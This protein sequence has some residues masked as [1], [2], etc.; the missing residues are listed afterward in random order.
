MGASTNYMIKFGADA[1]SVTKAIN[2]LNLDM[3]TLNKVARDSKAAFKLTGDTSQLQTAIT[4]TEKKFELAKKK[5]QDLE[6]ALNGL[7]D[8]NGELPDTVAAKKL[9]SQATAAKSDVNKL[10]AELEDLGKQKAGAEIS[11]DM[12]KASKSIKDAEGSTGKLHNSLKTSGV[13]LGSFIG[14]LGGNIASAGLGMIA[15]VFSGMGSDILEASDS[16]DKFKSTMSFAGKSNKEITNLTNASKKYAD[17]TVYD[18]NTILNT[19]AQLG[20]N[21]V[22]NYGKLVQAAGNLN[23]VVGG[24]NDT[25]GSLSMVLTQTA[26][27][28][29]L[30]TDN[31]NQVADAIPGAS[32]KLQD[33]MKKNGAYTGNFRDAMEK[34]QISSEEFNKAIMDLGMTDTAKKAASSTKTIEGAVGNLQASV[35]TVG[36][37]M[38]NAIK[39]PLTDAIS[40]VANAIPAI[41]TQISGMFSGIN[42]GGLSTVITSIQAAFSKLDFSGLKDLLSAIIPGLIAGFKSFVSSATPGITMVVGAFKNL[43]NALQPVFSVIGSMLVPAFKILGSYL[44]GLF[45]G[46]LSAVS[47]AFNGVAV[48]VKILTPVIRL[49]GKVFTALTPIFS[50]VANWL[51]NLQGS[52]GATSKIFSGVG[53]VLGS[54]G[55]GISS[56]FAGVW[57]RL[58]GAFGSMKS[59]FSAVGRL[60]SSVAKGIGGIPGRIAGWFSGIGGRIAAKFGNVKSIIGGKFSNIVGSISKHFSGITKIG[61]NVVKGIARGITG[62][63]SFLKGII[64]GFVGNTV[65]FIKKLFKIHSPSRL[66]RDEVGTFI[67]QGIGVGMT[68]SKAMGKI[69]SSARTVTNGVVNAFGSMAGGAGLNGGIVRAG[70][71]ATGT[72]SVSTA[73]NSVVFNISGG[74]PNQTANAVRKVL[75]QEKLI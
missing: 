14:T 15:D 35:Q 61:T 71:M 47:T 6:T 45:N 53:K 63:L 21:G 56:T 16:L 59:G 29:K 36:M 50:K 23:A 66:M 22:D 5:A 18:L 33:A 74:D 65:S 24:N 60:F 31:W 43:W 28:G 3:K 64:K 68:T 40:F 73:N 42:A 72:S 67:T 13:A 75:R 70:S 27:A 52:F 34:G 26:G 58:S 48:V 20:A 38:F 39:K 44:G 30:T 51:G 4:A 69:N 49:I 1:S 32:M 2:G 11:D 55:R 25:F 57:S 10:G 37:N 62:G 12:D 46:I 17:D 9:A 41:S 8:E 7:R 19:T 54:V